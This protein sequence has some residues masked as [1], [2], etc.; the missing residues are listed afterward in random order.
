[1]LSVLA[2]VGGKVIQDLFLQ[3]EQLLG[4]GFLVFLITAVIVGLLPLI[5]VWRIGTGLLGIRDALG[6]TNG[7]TTIATSLKSIA[8]DTHAAHELQ[9]GFQSTAIDDAA[10]AQAASAKDQAVA[11]KEQ[12]EAMQALA[13][14]MELAVQWY[15]HSLQ[16]PANGGG[17]TKSK[18]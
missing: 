16:G 15:V 4:A 5:A 17:S 11:L 9:A 10:L 6:E 2:T 8:V 14:Q 3:V 18:K 13:K 12:A 7:R 1:M